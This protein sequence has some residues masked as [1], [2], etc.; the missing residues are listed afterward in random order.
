M[1]VN[2]KTKQAVM[3]SGM[4]IGF[5]QKL[6]NPNHDLSKELSTKTFMSSQSTMSRVSREITNI[7]GSGYLEGK[8]VKDI[9]EDIEKKYNQ[10]ESW[11]ARRIARTETN[12]T[13][14][15]AHYQTYG[16]LKVEYHQWWTALDERVRDGS[17]G[18]ADHVEMH[19]K[20]VA[21]GTP[22]SNGLMYPGDTSGDIAEWINCR[23]ASVPFIM[24]YGMMAP[25]GM[26]E[27]T[28]DDLIPI[29]GFEKQTLQEA[30]E[31]TQNITPEAPV[32]G[33][34][35]FDPQS[36]IPD[37]KELKEL[38]T[39]LNK[40][41]LREYSKLM[42]EAKPLI[43]QYESATLEEQMVIEEKL[44]NIQNA[45]NELSSLGKHTER[46]ILDIPEIN[47]NEYLTDKTIYENGEQKIIN[48]L[49]RKQIQLQESIHYNNDEVGYVGNYSRQWYKP[50]NGRI[51]NTPEYQEMLAEKTLAGADKSFHEYLN[52]IE[53][54][55]DSAIAK[56]PTLQ[57][58][59]V[60]YR[61]GYFDIN[62]SKGE[63]GEWKAYTSTSFQKSGTSG[64]V[65]E[66]TYSIKILANEKTKGLAIRG[67]G[68]GNCGF[69]EEHEFLLGRNQ[70]YQVLDINYNTKEVT[71]LLL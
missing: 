61:E 47:M 19:G 55:L 29:P 69:A 53:K 57:N 59:T 63:I 30:M 70:K 45:M 51:Y 33:V 39:V 4:N 18:D 36:I 65:D 21:V 26:V 38:R 31:Q 54:N 67:I 1:L 41:Q 42:S 24:P 50:L 60:L 48:L 43:R 16:D 49:E 68:K 14:N 8:G 9:A 27:F 11:E 12:S 25:E 34:E 17:K 6:F 7:I 44:R 37:K 56:S 46:M 10:L 15:M 64:F 35:I 3:K 40:G 32:G 62:L 13:A 52:N 22:F 28:E 66:N 2:E 23:C 20:I 5:L 71:I 58:K